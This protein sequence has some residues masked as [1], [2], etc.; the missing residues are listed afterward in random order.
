MHALPENSSHVPLAKAAVFTRLKIPLFDSSVKVGFLSPTESYIKR[1]CD[2][3]DF[4][5]TNPRATY[6]MRVEGNRFSGDR[7][8]LG[9][10]LVVDWSHKA[11]EGKIV[12]VWFNRE[13]TVKRIHHAQ[14]MVVLMAFNSKY[15]PI[16]VQSDDIFR[17][18]GVVTYVIFKSL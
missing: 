2:L 15:D 4:C 11:T 18:F 8:E 16:Y 5:V 12:V 13:H 10:V 3:N 9:D 7:N 6:F 1:V 17:I 14:R